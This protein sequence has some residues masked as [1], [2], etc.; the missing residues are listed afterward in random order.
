MNYRKVYMK[1]ISNAINDMK[2]GVRKKK[3]GSY[4]ELHH[5]LPRSL[6][7]L[8]EKKRENLVLLT[9]REHFFC[10]QL[11][12]KIWPCMQIASALHVMS[13]TRCNN[14][15]IISSR[16]YERIRKTFVNYNNF[17]HGMRAGEFK[18]YNNGINE[19][20]SKNCPNG[21]FLGRISNQ[22]AHIKA[23]LTNKEL[24][25]TR[26]S[27]QSRMSEEKLA[28]WRQHIIENHRDG[29]EVYKNM[30]EEIKLK[31]AEKISKSLMGHKID[32]KAV[33]RGILNSPKHKDAVRKSA[34]KHK[35]KRFFNN[36]KI[37]ILAETCPEGFVSGMLKR[38]GSLKKSQGY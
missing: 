13:I 32:S 12:M 19:I 33:S 27:A 28:E 5:I 34:E 20:F 31:R 14:H 30:S 36:G 16:E 18:W 25:K 21:Y 37:C 17:S 38:Q 26:G 1:I 35:G 8:W 6:F 11:L 9:A 29:K 2:K 10:H 24:N 15:I 23:G 22:E 7:S 4:Y 3:S